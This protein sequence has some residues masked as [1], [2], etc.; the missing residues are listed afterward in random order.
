[1]SALGPLKWH[2]AQRPLHLFLQGAKVVRRFKP[3]PR[4][5]P[6]LKASASASANLLDIAFESLSGKLLR[7][8]DR[9]NI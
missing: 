9:R 5:H 4:L 2:R 6:T 3:P 7:I 1:M 8:H